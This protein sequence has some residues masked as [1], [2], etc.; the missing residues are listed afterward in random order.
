MGLQNDKQE[1]A[2][3]GIRFDI[4][5]V[6]AGSRP[7]GARR[8]GEDGYVDPAAAAGS[9]RHLVDPDRAERAAGEPLAQRSEKQ[10]PH[11]RALIARPLGTNT[12]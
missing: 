10:D 1:R 12:A 8:R 9:R 4:R 7:A 2:E 3:K 5:T 6:V 11:Q